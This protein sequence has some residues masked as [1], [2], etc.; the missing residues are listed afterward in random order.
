MP[1]VLIFRSPCTAGHSSPAGPLLTSRTIVPTSCCK[2][3]ACHSWESR[4]IILRAWVTHP[5]FYSFASY[6]HLNFLL[7]VLLSAVSFLFQR[8]LT[9]SPAT[10]AS[11]AS[12][13]HLKC[14]SSLNMSPSRFWPSPE[15]EPGIQ[16]RNCLGWFLIFN[17]KK[18]DLE[19]LP[20][21]ENSSL[22][23]PRSV[24][25]PHA[26]S[27]LATLCFPGKRGYTST[28]QPAVCCDSF[29]LPSSSRCWYREV[30]SSF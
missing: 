10:P 6:P 28:V 15:F 5:S 13:Y 23:T 27:S 18:T 26:L 25:F 24:S 8:L 12:H 3:T 19:S 22:L 2:G 11:N 17:H 14:A 4:L 20:P 30:N 1:Q 7:R 21:I 9:D 29:C 16:P